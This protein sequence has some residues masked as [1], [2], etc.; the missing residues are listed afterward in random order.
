MSK[1]TTHYT[2][3]I[4]YLY[5]VGERKRGWESKREIEWER[6]NEIERVKERKEERKKD[7]ERERNKCIEGEIEKEGDKVYRIKRKIGKRHKKKKE[8]KKKTGEVIER[9]NL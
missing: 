5:L 9:E 3:N 1:Y 2:F 7:R 6:E 8:E 4:I